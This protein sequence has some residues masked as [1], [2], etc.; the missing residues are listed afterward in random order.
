MIENLT[1]YNCSY[2]EH[3]KSQKGA[4]WW[5]SGDCSSEDEK[6]ITQVEH[7]VKAMPVDGRHAEKAK[8][9]RTTK[10]KGLYGKEIIQK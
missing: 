1:R 4:R 6:F 10:E 8:N 2:K 3:A 7:V 9:V 5:E